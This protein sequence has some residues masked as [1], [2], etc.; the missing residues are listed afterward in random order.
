MTSS[1]SPSVI[2]EISSHLLDQLRVY[3]TLCRTLTYHLQP[4]IQKVPLTLSHTLSTPFVY[5]AIKKTLL[6][7]I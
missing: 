7:L 5:L 6:L 2:N 3:L 4:D 1:T